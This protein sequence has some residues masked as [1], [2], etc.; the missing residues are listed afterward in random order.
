[1]DAEMMPEAEFVEGLRARGIAEARARAI[2]GDGEATD[3]EARDIA[4]TLNVRLQDVL[5]AGL[6]ETME[7]AVVRAGEA[8][9][10]LFPGGNAPAYR[11]RELARTPHQPLVK[12]FSL[13]VLGAG[14][15]DGIL[16]H[17]LHEYVFNYGRAPVRLDWAGTRSAPLAPGASAYVAPAVPH[18]IAAEGGASGEVLVVRIPGGLTAAALDEFATFNTQARHR[19]IRETERWF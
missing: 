17:G 11:V 1:M 13:E 2:L 5:V 3:H 10:R 8:R 18:R 4:A 16:S 6:D 15:Q 19:A 9:E 14:G 12:S 7:V